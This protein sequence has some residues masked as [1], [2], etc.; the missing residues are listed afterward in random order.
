[1]GN[2]KMNIASVLG[3]RLKEALASDAKF[4]KKAFPLLLN[5]ASS[6]AQR[7]LEKQKNSIEYEFRWGTWQHTGSWRED[8][9][10]Q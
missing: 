6:T 8:E 3:T 4:V 2:L 9:D 5:T 1:M 7:E 10:Q